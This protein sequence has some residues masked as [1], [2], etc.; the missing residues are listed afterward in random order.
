[1]ATGC[2]AGFAILLAPRFA[3]ESSEDVQIAFNLLINLTP[4]ATAFACACLIERNKVANG[5]VAGLLSVLPTLAVFGLM[6]GL[7][8]WAVWLIL[9]PLILSLVQV[10]VFSWLAALA[11]SWIGTK[12][13]DRLLPPSPG[14]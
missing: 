11:G 5:V 13:R 9:L 7:V 12:W 8:I 1:M 4:V 2:V 14:N 3:R 6:G 10:A